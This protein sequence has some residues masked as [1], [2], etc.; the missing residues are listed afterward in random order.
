MDILAAGSQLAASGVEAAT[1]T[2]NAELGFFCAFTLFRVPV[3]VG[4]RRGIRDRKTGMGLSR[5]YGANKN[6]QVSH[7]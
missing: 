7:M 5:P 2:K 6:L 1:A 3:G 4:N